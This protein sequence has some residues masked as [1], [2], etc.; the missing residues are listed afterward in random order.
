MICH[1]SYQYFARNSTFP[2]WDFT[3]KEGPRVWPISFMVSTKEDPQM[4]WLWY[5]QFKL[6]DN[7]HPQIKYFTGTLNMNNRSHQVW[8]FTNRWT[9]ILNDTLALPPCMGTLAVRGDTISANWSHC[10]TNKFAY[11]MSPMWNIMSMLSK[12]LTSVLVVL[13]DPGGW[14]WYSLEPS[15]SACNI[16]NLSMVQFSVSKL[17]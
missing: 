5:E 4:I 17:A 10:E 3:G 6:Y 11:G 9:R 12:S 15:T 13:R 7:L 1:F 2:S 8:C 16:R 14:F